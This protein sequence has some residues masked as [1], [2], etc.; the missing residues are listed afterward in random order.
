MV[1]KCALVCYT[2]TTKISLYAR[3]EMPAPLAF[4]NYAESKE[5]DRMS[6][7]NDLFDDGLSPMEKDPTDEIGRAH[8]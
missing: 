2:E 1:D 6:R 7:E 4:S 5:D 3:G 8:V